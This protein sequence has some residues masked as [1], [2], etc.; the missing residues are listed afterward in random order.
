MS[1]NYTTTFMVNQTPEEAFAAINNVRGW[2]SEEV[3]GDTNKLG[4]EFKYHYKDVHSATFK[5]TEFV[6]GKKVVWHVLDNHF[7]FT[8]DQNEW[9][10]N[11]M[12][13][14]IAKKGDKTEVHFTQVGL[15]PDY[16][17]YDV[18]SNAW[19]S[20]IS[21]SL[22][23]LISTGKGQPNPIEEVVTKAQEMS[24][25]NYS[26]TFTV[27]QT[28]EEVFAAINNVRGWWSD[29]IVGSADKPGAEFEARFEDIHRSVQRI[30]EFVPGQKIVWHVLDS[31][32]SYLKD[33]TEW[34]G[35]DIVFEITRK[36]DK[37]EL[38][39]THLGLVPAIE[40][41]GS[42]SNAWGFYVNV[43][44]RSLIMHGKGQPTL[45]ENGDE[46]KDSGLIKLNL[47]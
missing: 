43:S 34:N 45:K 27:N 25:Q 7:N 11:D 24:Q 41:Y 15:V 9:I 32:L 22:R 36:D 18:C 29:S 39:F 33:K 14:E 44:L 42:C 37:T 46:R 6:S 1:N 47:T 40:C 12:V 4:A 13:F 2:W 38:R 21:R 5:I 31:N 19:G 20:Y 23:D 26:T 8:Q 16:E 30:T 10:D 17:C 28:P 35:T 3:E